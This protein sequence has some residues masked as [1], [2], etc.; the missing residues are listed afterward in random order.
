MIY[1]SQ[2][3]QFICKKANQRLQITA[4]LQIDELY[5]KLKELSPQSFG[6]EMLT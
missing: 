6:V 3:H 2:L 5:E 4:R 1:T